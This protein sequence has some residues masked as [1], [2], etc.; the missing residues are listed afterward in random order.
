MSK[1]R[2]FRHKVNKTAHAAISGPDA[3]WNYA[4]SDQW[5]EITRQEFEREMYPEMYPICRKCGKEIEHVAIR[6]MD[7]VWCIDCYYGDDNSG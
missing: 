3:V 7:E 6:S 4:T 1:M 2:Y 5:D